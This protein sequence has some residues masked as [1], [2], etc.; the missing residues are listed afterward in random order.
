MH[1]YVYPCS[2][3]GKES[4]CTVGDLGSIPGLGSSPGERKDSSTPVSW[5]GE[6]HGLYS[7]W[8]HKELDMT[9]LSLSHRYYTII[10][11]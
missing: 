10:Y 1:P 4:S 7:P 2:S 11:N 3:A 5:P 8:D 9:E 6:L